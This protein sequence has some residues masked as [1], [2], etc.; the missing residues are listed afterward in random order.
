[1]KNFREIRK[2][3]RE[4]VLLSERDTTVYHTIPGIKSTSSQKNP[5]QSNAADPTIMR[6]YISQ[7]LPKG[8]VKTFLSDPGKVKSFVGDV[9]KEYPQFSED[10]IKKS[11]MYVVMST[12]HDLMSRGPS[13]G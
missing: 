13:R 1:M 11:V 5:A 12:D 7:K 3:I 9:K 10:D 6:K 8:Q 2:L 4:Y